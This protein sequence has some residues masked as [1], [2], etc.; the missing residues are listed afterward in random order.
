MGIDHGGGKIL[1]PKQVLN[2]ADVSAALQQM[3]GEGMAKSMGADGLR[4]AGAANRHLDGFVDDARVNMMAAGDT[5]MRVYGEV[6]GREDILP[7]P[8]FGSIRIL[9]SQSIGQIDLAMPL[10]SILLM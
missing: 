8:F 10:S 4:Q 3:D 6:P 9:P 2:S 5:S 1:V 7:A